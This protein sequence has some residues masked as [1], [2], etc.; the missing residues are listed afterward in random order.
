MQAGILELGRAFGHADGHFGARPCAFGHARG[1]GCA[2][3]WAHALA[4]WE[5]RQYFGARARILA[6]ARAFWRSGAHLDTHCGHFGARE[7]I[8][9]R[10]R[11][12]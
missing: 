11:A 3:V 10:V 2:R 5:R 12:F 6:R 4:F 9:A 7:R 1:G 8:W